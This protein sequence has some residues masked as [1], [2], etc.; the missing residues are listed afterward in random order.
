M[1]VANG[2]MSGYS[3]GVYANGCV[4]NVAIGVANGCSYISAIL[5]A[6]GAAMGVYM[7]ESYGIVARCG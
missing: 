6:V 1:F 3:C 2:I 4:A 7:C 5:M